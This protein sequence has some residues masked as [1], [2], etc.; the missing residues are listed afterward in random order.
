MP[1]FPKVGK[2]IRTKRDADRALDRRESAAV[3]R[4]SGGLCEVYEV[5]TNG[6][7]W[8]CIARAAHVMHLIGGNGRRGRGKS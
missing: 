7:A 5:D 6:V 1:A 3:R 8:P 4:R 2:R